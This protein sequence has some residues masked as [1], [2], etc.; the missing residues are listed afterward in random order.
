MDGDYGAVAKCLDTFT[1]VLENQHD[2]VCSG[3]SY[4]PLIQREN[5]SASCGR[6]DFASTSYN[7][8]YVFYTPATSSSIICLML[9]LMS[10]TLVEDAAISSVDA[11]KFWVLSQTFAT[12]SRRF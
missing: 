4:V 1:R 7:V 10:I 6:V 11:A 12:T 8:V 9:L 2:G 5:P 3:V